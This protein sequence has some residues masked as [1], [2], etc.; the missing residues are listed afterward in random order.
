MDERLKFEAVHTYVLRISC[1]LIAQIR[2]V[3]D[4]NLEKLCP[5]PPSLHLPPRPNSMDIATIAK[6]FTAHYYREFSLGRARLAPLY[7][8]TSIELDFPVFKRP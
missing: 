3:I 7:V 2:K 4:R 6:N 8:S 5:L 1:S